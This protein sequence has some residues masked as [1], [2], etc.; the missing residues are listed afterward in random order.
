MPNPDVM[1]VIR[2]DFDSP[3]FSIGEWAAIVKN[4]WRKHGFTAIDLYKEHANKNEIYNAI[5]DEDPL[6]F[7]G[8]GHGSETEF[9]GQ[10]R[11]TIFSVCDCSKL[12][13]RT[14]YLMSCLTATELGP[15]MINK[16][17]LAYMGWLV[18]YTWVND[19]SGK[20]EMELANEKAFG[21]TTTIVPMLYLH[22]ATWNHCF[23]AKAQLSRW[24]V[25]FW[26]Q[27]PSSYAAEVI[28][29]ITHDN[30]DPPDSAQYG[31]LDHRR[32]SENVHI[33]VIHAIRK[34]RHQINT[35]FKMRVFVACPQ[36]CDLRGNR[37]Q[38]MDEFNDIKAEGP[39]TRFQNGVCSTDLFEI[40]YPHIGRF[41]WKARFLGDALHPSETI[42]GLESKMLHLAFTD[43]N[44]SRWIRVLTIPEVMGGTINLAP[45]SYA[46]DENE[47]VRLTAYPDSGYKFSGWILNG[48]P[49]RPQ[50]DM[51]MNPKSFLMTYHH[52]IMPVFASEH[53]LTVNSS[54]ITSI[55]VI[56]NGAEVGRT[57]LS[58]AIP[59]GDHIISVPEEVET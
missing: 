46:Y 35:P 19:L 11:E 23:Q 39:I 30:I 31:N 42:G 2:P 24:W 34:T 43:P 16:G 28:K 10:M 49:E 13:G 4:Y 27:D 7:Y 38:V 41:L 25:E 20:R 37:I 17:A 54:P 21:T 15:D 9:T 18:S 45:G 44:W 55:Q 32:V 56:L 22:N 29:W 3:T 40:T 57:P 36:G 6:F 12:S 33:P 5:D 8:N 53:T 51:T 14:V 50:G 58:V 52:H 47:L 59:A 1:L 48:D 26:E